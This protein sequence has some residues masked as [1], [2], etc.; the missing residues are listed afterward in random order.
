MS[1]VTGGHV[2]D[3]SAA[4]GPQESAARPRERLLARAFVRL[5]DTLVE[6]FDVVDFLQSLS[7]DSVEIL[8]AEA[9]GVMLADPRGG[10]RLLASSEERMRILELFEIQG[11][12]GPCLDAFGSGRT[13]QANTAE[14]RSRWPEFAQRASAAGFGAMCAVPLQ[15]RKNVI[16][17]LNL[18]RGTDE[19]FSDDDLEI[20]QAMAGVAAIALIQ[21]RAIRERTLVSEQLEAALHSR[22]VIEQA[23]GMLAEYLATSVDEAFI[24]LRRYARDNNQKLTSVAIGVVDRQIPSQALARRQS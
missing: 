11:A 18:F 7:S 19:L 21:E 9:A 3:G 14:G 22:I 20:A 23:K 17:A 6:E 1:E 16:G 8:G 2:R 24:L 10:L 12:Q 4:P 13:V 15:V 5:A